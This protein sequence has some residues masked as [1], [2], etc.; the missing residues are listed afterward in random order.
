MS[1]DNTG[2]VWTPATLASELAKTKPPK[3]INGITLHHTAAPSL[4]QRPRGFTAQHLENLRDY[5]SKQLGWKA[6]PHFFV[7]DDQVF[8][9]S[10]WTEPGIH[11]VSFNSTH[12]GIEVLG[13]YDTEDPTTGRGLACWQTAAATV[14]VLLKWLGWKDSAAEFAN[15]VNFH[16]NDPKTT[17]TCPGQRVTRG[18][19]LGLLNDAAKRLPQNADTQLVPVVETLESLGV[20][21]GFAANAIWVDG[22]N[23]TRVFGQTLDHAV[24]DKAKKATLAPL[25]ELMALSIP[26]RALEARP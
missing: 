11:A 19:F 18:F 5:Y 1:Y 25:E 6:G 3:W 4:E 9:L 21:S 17:K 26:A 14:R 7:D 16:R 20:A 24:Y 2:R 15:A 22:T 8:G 12:I 10:P 13:D 23:V